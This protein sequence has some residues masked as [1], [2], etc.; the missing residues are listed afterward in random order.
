MTMRWPPLAPVGDSGAGDLTDAEAPF[1]LTPTPPI[2]IGGIVAGKYRVDQVIGFG[3]MGIVCAATHLEL[4]TPI[5]IKFVRPERGSD[6]RAVA[7]FLTEARAAAQLQSQFACRVMDCG[8]LPSGSPYI[9]M[10]YLVGQDL[11]SLVSA[12]GPLDIEQAISL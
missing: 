12:Q 9:V 5:A 8:R 1:P 6:E 11:R 2:A 7:R 3:G 4:A 10:E